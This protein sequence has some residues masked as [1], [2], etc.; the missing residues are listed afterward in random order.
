M[1]IELALDPHGL[2]GLVAKA[3]RLELG[4]AGHGVNGL[5]ERSFA[6]RTSVKAGEEE[7][8]HVRQVWRDARD[9]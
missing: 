3:A 2:K 1:N 8:L 9:A 4:W 7:K 5:A 6:A